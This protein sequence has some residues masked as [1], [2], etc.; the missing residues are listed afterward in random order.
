MKTKPNITAQMDE[1]VFEHRNKMYGAYVLRKMYHRQLIRALFLATAILIAGLVY[2]LVL[3]YNA[4]HG[5]RNVSMFDGPVYMPDGPPPAEPP[6]LPPPPPPPPAAEL[7]K[8]VVF[9]T[10]QVVEGEVPDDQGLLPM[11]EFNKTVNNYLVDITPEKP[12]DNQPEVI[13]DPETA[14]PSISVEEM[15]SFPGGE[16]ARIKFL[17]DSII[18]PKL[19]AE[20]GIQGT[21]YLQFIVNSKGNIT[22]AKVLRGIGGGCDEEALRVVNAMPQWKPGKQNG[23]AVRVIYN[24]GINFSLR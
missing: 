14:P 4:M 5:G 9:V 17:S 13:V 12:V 19:A 22:D 1:I 23:R 6:A 8:R 2:P 24:M 16:S 11:D 18:Y 10:P 7:V 20:T 21:V 15:P 3:S